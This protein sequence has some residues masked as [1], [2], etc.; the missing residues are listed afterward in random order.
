LF[1][2]KEIALLIWGEV[3]RVETDEMQLG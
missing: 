1:F 3:V 2:L